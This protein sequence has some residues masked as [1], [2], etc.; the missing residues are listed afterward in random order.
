MPADGDR[1]GVDEMA[2][3]ESG[4]RRRAAADIDA[5]D[6]E[7]ALLLARCGQGAGVGRGDERAHREIA[8]LD[9]QHQV[10]HRRLVGGDRMQI[11][12]QTRG[13]HAA[14]IV[15][16]RG[17][18][19][20]EAD[21]VEMYQRAAV[22]LGIARGRRPSADRCRRRARRRPSMSTEAAKFDD[23]SRPHETETNTSSSVTCA[24]RSAWAMAART[25]ASASARSVMTPALRPRERKWPMPSTR[26]LR[27]SPG[28]ISAARARQ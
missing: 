19:D 6:A 28:A 13:R 2:V 12:R 11:G 1:R 3:G 16:A 25:A 23:C 21:A 24:M 22:A 17:A 5:G 27:A 7:P 10:A 18:V 15:A 4:D 20:A 8:A 26:A 14:R 9:D